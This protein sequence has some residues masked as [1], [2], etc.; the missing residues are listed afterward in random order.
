M[1]PYAVP[2]AAI[3]SIS[4]IRRRSTAAVANAEAPQAALVATEM[5]S[6]VTSTSG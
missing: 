4:W 2:I 1:P 5:K 3:R 6:L